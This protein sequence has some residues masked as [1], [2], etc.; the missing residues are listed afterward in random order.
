MVYIWDAIGST[1]KALNADQLIWVF[2]GGASFF[3]GITVLLL[4]NELARARRDGRVQRFHELVMKQIDLRDALTLTTVFLHGAGKSPKQKWEDLNRLGE[5]R[6]VKLRSQVLTVFNFYEDLAILYLKNAIDRKM[7][8]QYF[9]AMC[10]TNYKLAE[11]LIVM[12]RGNGAPKVYGQWQQMV[13]KLGS[14]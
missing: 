7:V 6:Y 12:M 8:R 5:A 3:L 9:R 2:Q 14:T 1:L 13:R 4:L 10:I 11:P